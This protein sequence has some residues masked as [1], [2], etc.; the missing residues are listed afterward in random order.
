MITLPCANC[1]A[2]IGEQDFKKLTKCPYCNTK[3][4]IRNSINLLEK[5]VNETFG[6]EPPTFIPDPT[7]RSLIYMERL[8]ILSKI[9]KDVDTSFNKIKNFLVIVPPFLEPKVKPIDIL[10]VIKLH[11]K[12][13]YLVQK[14][15]LPI[16]TTERE[17]KEASETIIIYLAK[18]YMLLGILNF[19]EGSKKEKIT[20]ANMFYQASITNF[21]KSINTLKNSK[22]IKPT[23]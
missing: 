8:K 20:E 7:L 2:A 1:G 6:E 11:F 5:W 10:T 18:S 4:N 12:L 23:F 21:E 16:S 22:N 14:Y 13:V 15:L 17:E 19:I 9:Q 3:L